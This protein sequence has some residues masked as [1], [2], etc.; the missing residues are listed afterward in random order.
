MNG[1]FFPR[2]TSV[3]D[4][5]P[6]I[7]RQIWNDKYRFK[8]IDGAPI[9]RSVED[10]W[11]RIARALAAEE[12]QPGLW[13]DEFYSALVDFK[14][15]PG[16]R[17]IA[18]AG[19]NRAITMFNCFVMG[20][21]ED[22]LG[23]VFQHVR[24]SAL[25]AQQSGGIGNDFSS[26]R[27]RGSPVKRAGTV[28]AGPVLFMEVW[29]SM[30]QTIKSAGGRH[31]AMMATLRCDHPDIEEFIEVKSQKG[32]LRNFNLSVLVT[33]AFVEAVRA[34]RDW[35]L[36]FGDTTFRTIKAAELWDK[37]MQA[38]FKYAEP[39]VIFIDRINERNNLFYCESIHCV[40]P[41]GEQPLPHYGACDLGAMNLAAFVVDPFTP[42]AHIDVDEL[43]SVTRIAVRMLDN[44]IDVS[45]YPLPAQRQ[46]AEAKRRIGLGITGLA[47]ALIM[48][49][50][51]YGS[52]DAAIQASRWQ[53]QLGRVAYLTSIDLAIEKGPFPLFDP[54]KYFSNH[55]PRDLTFRGLDEKIR[56][57]IS[58]HG[59]R[60]AL[61]TTI[62]PTGTTSLFARNVSSGIEPLFDLSYK[63]KVRQ[64]DGSVA[65][66]E[67]TSYAVTLYRSKFGADAPLPATF[68]TAQTLTPGDHIR[69]QGAMQL[70]VDSSISK[71]VNC[72]PNIDFESFKQ[73][74]LTAYDSG[75][76]GC[77]TYLPNE[78]TGSVIE[79]ALPSA[80]A[81]T[82]VAPKASTAATAASPRPDEPVARPDKLIGATY[83]LQL[84]GSERVFYL[85]INDIEIDGH[86]SPFEIFV[87][88]MNLE[89]CAWVV[90]LTSTIST[91]FQSGGDL[92]LVVK[93]LK[94]INDLHGRTWS[95]GCY[96]SS[97]IAEIHS[98]IESH[99]TEIGIAEIQNTPRESTGSSTLV[100]ANPG[101]FCPKCN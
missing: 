75:C 46:E 85:T 90:G 39:G 9:D 80:T 60:N 7:S 63:R 100:W 50:L 76:K 97:L 56:A 77:T 81:P 101:V 67:I 92:P 15:I 86:R 45:G 72:P 73:I 87:N 11:R 38:N 5:L 78:I 51:N 74:Y 93:E 59:V 71:T 37:I 94:A 58:E 18:G 88:S 44:V 13:R 43:A 69:M 29:D 82:N 6:L 8:S 53:A 96:S 20:E 95:Q 17:I 41:C 70:G 27:P 66:E 68:V 55:S 62:A 61:L 79:S 3:L 28:A 42:K 48:C 12:A 49:G 4:T 84:P 98:I 65:I 54:K 14:F 40:N 31:A 23:N 25:T 47:D 10:T 36:V 33:D 24:E 83:K 22:D 57:K 2:S 99:M 35:P 16:G 52:E 91:V 34:N 32:R 1:M 30:C 19:T 64:L 21:I 89:D 26:L